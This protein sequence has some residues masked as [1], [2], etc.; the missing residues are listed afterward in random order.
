M[1]PT[2][3]E[4]EPSYDP[5]TDIVFLL[6]T[7]R[8]RLEPQRLTF[9]MNTVR[10][11]NWNPSS[12]LRFILHGWGGNFETAHNIFLTRDFLNIADHNVVVIDWSAGR[13][14]NLTEIYYSNKL[15]KVQ[16]R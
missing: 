15:L 13:K 8:N 6:F 12:G 16:A 10:N 5:M 7:Q 4:I 3:V 14:V 11:S 9:D 1:N 2:N